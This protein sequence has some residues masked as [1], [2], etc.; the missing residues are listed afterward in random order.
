MKISLILSL[1]VLTAFTACSGGSNPKDYSSADSVSYLLGY[2]IASSSLNNPMAIPGG[3]INLSEFSKGFVNGLD[4]VEALIQVD[5]VEMYFR[6]YAMRAQQKEMEREQTMEADSTLEIPEY[7]DVAIDTVSYL[8]GFDS[9]QR[10]HMN[11]L[12]EEGKAL[13]EDVLKVGLEDGFA[14]NEP[15]IVVDDNNAF[16]TAFFNAQQAKAGEANLVEAEEFLA[17]NAKRAGVTSLMDGQLQ[18]EVLSEGSG[19]KPTVDDQVEVHY[20]GMLIDGTV[21]DSSVERGEPATFSP[22]QVIKGWT[23]I[24]QL[25]PVGSKWKVFIH[26][27][28]AYGSRG[29]RTIPANS[30]LIFEIELISIK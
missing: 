24:L 20:H 13:S 7:I 17:E 1:V 19:A 25:M 15:K 23:E 28:L 3:E 6:Q 27:D 8:I 30:A 2:D 16:I 10:L 5:N 12:S 14:E 29:S 4:S 22:K 21:F 11:L 26:P 9:G 18:Y